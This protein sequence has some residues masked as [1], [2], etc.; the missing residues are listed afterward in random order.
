MG[1]GRVFKRNIKNIIAVALTA[2]STGGFTATF[3]S[4]YL[5][6]YYTEFML[7]S[8]A[9]VGTVL[10]IGILVD[11]VTDFAMGAVVDRVETRYGKARHWFLWM[12]VP[13][14]I[15]TALIFFCPTNASVTV[16]LVYL[17]IVY[18]L[19]CTCLTTVRLPAQSIISLCFNQDKARESA[20]LTYGFSTQLGSAISSCLIAPLLAVLGGGIMA[21]K[22]AAVIFPGLAGLFMLAAFFLLTEVKGSKAALKNVRETEEEQTDSDNTLDEKYQAQKREHFF[23]ELSYLLRNKYWVLNEFAEICMATSVGF[24]IGTATYFCKY[25]LGRVEAVGGVFGVMSIGMLSGIMVCAPLLTKIDAR[26]IAV[27]GNF[28]ACIGLCIASA[29]VFWLDKLGLL[30]VGIAIKQFGSGLYY[31]VGM[32]LVA[33]TVDY[34]EWKFGLRQDG[35][36]YSGKAVMNKIASSVAAAIL[37]FVL[38]SVGYAGG[39]EVMPAAAVTALKWLFLIIPAIA[40]FLAAVCYIFFNLPG[41]RVSRMQEEI[42]QRNKSGNNE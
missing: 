32:G 3:V 27:I 39:S 25:V 24:L 5:S 11:G 15:A 23:K 34:G 13:T 9:A 10:S 17:F 19:Y 6:F 33:R 38:T 31:A 2:L 36:A 18:N 20:S 4:T 7:V 8:A 26:K 1:N 35:I 40:L 14:A 16:K 28:I 30:Y 41:E 37:G 22:T 42:A 29:G 12:A 21:Y